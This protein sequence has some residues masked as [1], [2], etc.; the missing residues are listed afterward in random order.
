MRV[1]LLTVLAVGAAF[2]SGARIVDVRQ[3]RQVPVEGGLPVA[4]A[5]L[6]ADGSFVIASEANG[7]SLRRVDL[8][9]GKTIKIADN[10]SMSGLQISRDG[11]TVV[12]R[13]NSRDKRRLT[14]SSVHAADLSTGRE[15]A[16]AAPTRRLQGFALSDAGVVEAV[17]DGRAMARKPGKDAAETTGMPVVGIDR[18]HLVVTVAG[19]TRVLDP[20]GRGSYLWPQLSPDGRHI[21][22][23]KVSEGCFVCDTDGMDVRALGY[24][25]AATWLDNTTVVGMQDFDDGTVTTRSAIVAAR[26]DGSETQTLTDD[27]VVALFPTGSFDAGAITFTDNSGALYVMTISR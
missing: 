12:F 8:S 4:R 14:V 22:Y 24:L 26:A 2:S 6:S 25:H 15:A 20:Q 11:T 21:V 5:A 18:G 23:Y 16:V 10:G 3:V 13:Q 27:G 7:N 1:L 17:S 9:T 19:E